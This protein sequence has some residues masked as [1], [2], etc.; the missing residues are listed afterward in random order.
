MRLD[1]ALLANA[2]EAPPNGLVY[3]L[4]AGFDTL[5]RDQF[6]TPFGGVIVLR[7]QTTRLETERPHK[8]E[9]H[10]ADE[11]GKPVLPQPI[12][13]NLPAR[14]VPPEY[15]HGWDLA[16]N[17]V[18]NLTTVPIERPGFY[19]FAILIDDQQVRTLPFRAVKAAQVQTV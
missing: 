16:A 9:V 13:L 7:V 12:V 1:W 6:P 10:C 18:I 11:D 3:I 14:Q 8:I 17:I 19:N 2:A 5:I 15:P 4:G